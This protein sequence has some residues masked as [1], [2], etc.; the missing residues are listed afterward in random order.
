MGGSFFAERFP[1]CDARLN[2]SKGA[3]SPLPAESLHFPSRRK[4][5]SRHDAPRWRF[6]CISQQRPLPR[7]D[8]RPQTAPPSARRGANGRRP[9]FSLPRARARGRSDHPQ[10]RQRGIPAQP[11]RWSALS[12]MRFRHFVNTN[13][14]TR[15]GLKKETCAYADHMRT[16]SGRWMYQVNAGGET[17]A[18]FHAA[19][20]EPSCRWPPRQ[21][22]SSY[23]GWSGRRRPSE[24]WRS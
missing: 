15:R 2:I 19:L 3:S 7:S 20:T 21:R 14:N 4:A 23:E 16:S 11:R 1:P 17:P 10:R 6:L 18:S 24:R 22:R 5:F 9:P 13:G 12:S 8:P